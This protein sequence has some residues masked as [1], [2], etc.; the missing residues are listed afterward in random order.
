M[1]RKHEGQ[2]CSGG[3]RR[4]GTTR[5]SGQRQ[6]ATTK[7]RTPNICDTRPALGEFV[8]KR[9][10]ACQYV[11]K[12]CMLGRICSIFRVASATAERHQCECRLLAAVTGFWRMQRC[13]VM[14]AL[15]VR[16]ICRQKQVPASVQCALA[17][18]SPHSTPPSPW[19]CSPRLRRSCRCPMIL[20]PAAAPPPPPSPSAS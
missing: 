3:D 12:S 17:R 18:A 11:G 14:S 15:C 13:G 10:S 5:R 7:A 20:A 2:K 19:V 6:S 4:R 1:C 8:G 16:S 9:S